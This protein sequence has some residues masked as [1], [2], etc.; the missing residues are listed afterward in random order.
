[1]EVLKNC[2]IEYKSLSDSRR[3]MCEQSRILDKQ[4]PNSDMI[5]R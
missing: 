5:I 4:L 3:K 1:M 2:L